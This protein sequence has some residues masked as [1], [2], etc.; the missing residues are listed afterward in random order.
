V[1]RIAP[2]SLPTPGRPSA[3][4]TPAPVATP[5]QPAQ[6]GT[7]NFET[8]VAVLAPAAFAKSLAPQVAP[9]TSPAL[10][11]LIQVQ[12]R[13]NHVDPRPSRGHDDQHGHAVAPSAPPV[14]TPDVKPPVPPVVAVPPHVDPQPTHGNDDQHG[15][16]PPEPPPVAR[17]PVAFDSALP[18]RTIASIDRELAD[19][20][21]S[22]QARASFQAAAA[23]R[24]AQR[25][26]L[27]GQTA[28]VILQS[29]Q[30]DMAAFRATFAASHAA[31]AKAD[32]TARGLRA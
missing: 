31:S 7:A 28:M 10:A 23:A 21:I 14:Q 12:A 19:E 5:A 29:V 11:L 32:W 16:K 25:T 2:L 15:H 4:R 24:D 6:N 30:S 22:Q 8:P 27:Q 3:A 13:A 17:P 26:V 18:A 20:V 1:N 9:V